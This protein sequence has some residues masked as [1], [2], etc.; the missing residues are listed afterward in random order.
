MNNF[1]RAQQTQDYIVALKSVTGLLDNQ[2]L[3]IIQHGVAQQQGT[4][5]HEN[6]AI[7]FARWLSPEFGVW[8]NTKI[9]ELLLTGYTSLKQSYDKMLPYANYAY[10]ILTVSKITYSTTD[11]VKGHGSTIS[12]QEV[13]KRLISQKIL[14]KQ[15]NSPW[16][17]KAPY[18]KFGYTT[19]VTKTITKNGK[20]V[21]VATVTRWTETGKLFL[22]SVLA[23]WGVIKLPLSENMQNP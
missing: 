8:C 4:W 18:D 5:M 14:S 20:P 13:Y 1:L 16:Y 2:I 10:D 15:K 3:I 23:S 12:T 9:R 11:I 17:L 7:E 22:A 6:L 19:L 21:P